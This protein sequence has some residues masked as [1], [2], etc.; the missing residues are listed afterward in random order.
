MTMASTQVL[1]GPRL[2]AARRRRKRLLAFLALLIVAPPVMAERWGTG[3]PP[4]IAAE[5]SAGMAEVAVE[6]PPFMAPGTAAG[7]HVWSNEGGP[8]GGRVQAIEFIDGHTL[9]AGTRHAGVFVSRDGG[10][11]WQASNRGLSNLVVNCICRNPL[12]KHAVFIGT[13]GSGIFRTTNAATSGAWAGR[14]YHLGN[15]DVTAIA[16]S[17]RDTNV[18]FA[19]TAAGIYRSPNSGGYWFDVTNDLSDANV[20]AVAIGGARGVDTIYVGTNSGVFRSRDG[21]AAWQNTSGGLTNPFVNSLLVDQRDS[22]VILAATYG[23]VFKSID[24]GESWVAKNSGLGCL[25][26]RDIEMHPDDSSIYFAGTE[27]GFFVSANGG[28]SWSEFSAGLGNTEVLSTAVDATGDQLVAGTYWGGVYRSVSDGNRSASGAAWIHMVK[29]MHNTFITD[30]DIDARDGSLIQISS[31]GQVF[32]S[33]D[34]GRT[35]R[36]SSDGIEREDLTAIA[37]DHAAPDT[38]YCGAYYGGVC[39]STDGGLTWLPM[40]TGLASTTVTCLAVDYRRDNIVFAGTYD[41]LYRSTDGGR[42]WQ[43]KSD[44]ISDG[45]IWTIE[46]D[47]VDASI[48]F[49]GTYG[50]GIFKTTDFGESWAAINKGLPERYVKAIAIDP[51][52]HNIVYAGTYYNGGVYKSTDGGATWIA[53]SRGLSNRDV[54]SLAVDPNRREQVIAGTCGGVFIS[55]DGAG[56][57]EDVSDGLDVRETRCVAYDPAGG[58][59]VYAGTYGGGLYTY[60]GTYCNEREMAK[61]PGSN[62]ICNLLPNYPNPFNPSTAV[63]FQIAGRICSDETYPV[64]MKVYNVQGELVKTLAEGPYRAGDY[65]ATWRGDDDRGAQVSAGIYFCRL[66]VKS[67]MSSIK[68]ILV[69]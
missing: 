32:R 65:V 3:T 53:S 41:F 12:N 62:G 58:G 4:G 14:S 63:R 57:W 7:D 47:P 39:K 15:G 55:L 69:R 17:A 9:L 8:C 5:P 28:E 25:Y 16:M 10:A 6:M 59:T 13:Q 44:G 46:A 52:D 30:I 23:G 36:E 35:W 2:E 26:V 40:N 60:S 48:L 11:S 56:S 64:S 68:M 37:I 34:E 61:G 27:A 38:V 29:G 24:G 22:R 43:L 18:V 21:G 51:A 20:Y 50:G 45:H 33:G 67:S 66:Q 49:V 19:G 31:Y 1:A 54:W 42:H